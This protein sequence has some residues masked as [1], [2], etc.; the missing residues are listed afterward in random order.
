M[1]PIA[2]LSVAAIAI[3]LER[4]A[5]TILFN[6]ES[7]QFLR[8]L[9]SEGKEGKSFFDTSGEEL[10]RM[11]VNE[12]EDLVEQE[13]QLSFDG[14]FKNLEYLSAIGA[15]APLLGFIGTVSGMISSFQSISNVNKVSVRLVAGGISEALVTTGFGLIVAV[16]CLAGEHIFRFFLTARAHKLSEEISMLTRDTKLGRATTS[17]AAGADPVEAASADPVEAAGGSD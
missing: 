14:M 2:V 11:P 6:M 16:V 9:R 4:I 13:L 3:I 10:F 7:N 5:N 12:M 1:W 15:I 17:K 8:F